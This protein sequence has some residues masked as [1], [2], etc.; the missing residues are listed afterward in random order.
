ML[1]A[2]PVLVLCNVVP[3]APRNI[4][5]GKILAIQG[6]S[7]EC[8]YQV[9]DVKKIFKVISSLTFYTATS[10]TFSQTLCKKVKLSAS[11]AV[12]PKPV[13]S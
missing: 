9:L 3:E 4:S 13:Q 8:I 1:T 7:F 2:Y 12:L 6:M 10:Q 11:H 5:Q